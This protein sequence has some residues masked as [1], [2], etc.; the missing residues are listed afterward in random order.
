MS[1][2]HLISLH[3]VGTFF[4]TEFSGDAWHGMKK[5]FGSVWANKRPFINFTCDIVANFRFI[6]FDSTQS[7]MGAVACA[8]LAFR[9]LTFTKQNV[10]I[11]WEFSCTPVFEKDLSVRMTA[12]HGIWGTHISRTQ[13]LTDHLPCEP[14]TPRNSY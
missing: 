5:V 10:Y 8:W 11:I 14:L 1:G 12:C 13:A 2:V 7:K 4:S 6:K 9:M 3:W